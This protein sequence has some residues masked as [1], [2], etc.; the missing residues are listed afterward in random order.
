MKEGIIIN[1]WNWIVDGVVIAQ[2]FAKTK[3]EA[4]TYFED[5]SYGDPVEDVVIAP[6]NT[7]KK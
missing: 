2:C 4:V 6:F 5:V 1:K 7:E 3:Y